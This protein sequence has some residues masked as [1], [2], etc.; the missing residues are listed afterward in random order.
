MRKNRID[1]FLLGIVVALTGFEILFRS[2]IYIQIG[3]MAFIAYYFFREKNKFNIDFFL[4][5]F[6]F[7][8][9]IVFQATKFNLY[10]LGLKYLLSSVIQLLICYMVLEIIKNRFHITFVNFI[11]FLALFSLVFYPT[12]FIPSLE[13]FIK[14]TFGSILKPIGTGDLPESFRSKTLIFF[15]YHHT[16]GQDISLGFPRNC[17]AFWEPG[18]FVVFLNL[19]LLMNLYLNNSP[20]F[21]KK[22]IV[23]I[24]AI[25]TTL[26]TTGFIVLFLIILSKFIFQKDITKIILSLPIMLAIVYLGFTYVWA[27]DF[28]SEKVKS[29]IETSGESTKSRFGAVLY[30]I[31]VLKEFPLAGVVLKEEDKEMKISRTERSSSPNGLSLIFLIYGIPVGVIYFFLFYNG[32]SRW[33]IFNEINNK[34]LHLLF[35]LVFLLLAFS[36]DV[37]NRPFYKM[38]LF[39]ILCFPRYTLEREIEI[40][41]LK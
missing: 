21:S 15:T 5:V 29:N 26:S 37:T 2:S 6:L 17:G 28:M 24:V 40:Q 13:E 39:F 41:E 38:I 12:L 23:F 31:N 7:A 4:I 18:M 30:H 16:W 25:I 9:P 8:V 11:Y 22:N 34:M 36:Q 20:T 3:I 1:Y 32:I 27:L 10:T 35:F 14:S 19:A 33:L